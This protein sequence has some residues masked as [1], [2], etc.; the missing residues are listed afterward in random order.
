MGSNDTT[1][2]KFLVRAVVGAGSVAGAGLLPDASAQTLSQRQDANAAA[3]AT[4]TTG[5]GLGT[6]FNA[7][8]AATVA[9]FTERLMPGAPGKP[10]A[11]DAGVLNYIDLALSGAYAE[12]QDFYRRGLAQL[13]AYCRKTY[14]EPFARLDGTKQDAVIAALEQG[15][16]AGF[17]WP[18]AQAFFETIRTHTIEGMFADPVYGGN[19]D[20]AGWRLVGFP[21][22]QAVYTPADLQ[23]KQAFTRAPMMGLQSQAGN[24]SKT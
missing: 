6:F 17:T 16:A 10:G 7:Q 18:T 19:K 4:H 9:A 5:P 15:K 1:R 23:N 14:N 24:T 3:P 11:R 13:D 8:D 21:G 22:G 2:R 12:L 20:F